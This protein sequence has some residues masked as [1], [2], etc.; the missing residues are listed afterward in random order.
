MRFTADVQLEGEDGVPAATVLIA[1]IG[2][3]MTLFPDGLRIHANQHR[4]ID[5]RQRRTVG[6]TH[7]GGLI[8][9]QVDGTV[10]AS[11]LVYRRHC[12]SALFSAMALI[13]GARRAG[14]RSPTR[15]TIPQSRRMRGSGSP[16]AVRT[17]I[18]TRSTAGAS[19][20]TI[21]RRIRTTAIELGTVRRREIRRGLFKRGS[22]SRQG[23]AARLSPPCRGLRDP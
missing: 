19:S 15:P 21:R 12:G 13:I 3:T 1:R 23:I 16:Q 18:S 14:S 6:V 11:N 4:A 20:T 8:E 9:V 5:L 2:L 10:V 22:A 17:R 7:R